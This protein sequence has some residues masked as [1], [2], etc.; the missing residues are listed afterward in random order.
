MVASGPGSSL[1]S[2][3]RL[4][5]NQEPLMAEPSPAGSIR[6]EPLTKAAFASFG[7]VI[8]MAGTTA[9]P[10]NQGFAARFDDL[11]RVDSGQQGGRTCVALFTADPRPVPIAIELM[12]C[13]PIGSQTFYPLQDRP[14][15]VL[16]CADPLKPESYRAFRATGRQ[17]VNYAPNVWHHPLLVH[18]AGSRFLVVDRIGPGHNMDEIW[19]PADQRLWLRP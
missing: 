18:D 1:I 16:V 19:L 5:S 7:D 15:L 2:G 10:V 6:I 3:R 8:E 17:G 12:E 11:A 4:Q 14:W 13:H 9:K